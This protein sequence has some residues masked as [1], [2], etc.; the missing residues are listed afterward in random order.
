MDGTHRRSSAVPSL[1]CC[2]RLLIHRPRRRVASHKQ[3][4]LIS[5]RV[6]NPAF[7]LTSSPPKAGLLDAVVTLPCSPTARGRCP[8][9]QVK[10]IPLLSTARTTPWTF[11]MRSATRCDAQ[12]ADTF[13]EEVAFKMCCGCDFVSLFQSSF[14]FLGLF[15]GLVLLVLCMPCVLSSPPAVSHL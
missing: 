15:L 11:A 3:M 10:L 6:I 2:P 4:S 12:G 8:W 9:W 14:V 1:L 5:G 13:A 7:L